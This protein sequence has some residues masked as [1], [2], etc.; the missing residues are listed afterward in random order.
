MGMQWEFTLLDTITLKVVFI[1]KYSVLKTRFNKQ[2]RFAVFLRILHLV[3]Y[4]TPI[5]Y[6]NL[7][8]IPSKLQKFCCN[9]GLRHY[10][11]TNFTCS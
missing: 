5:Y 4:S 2:K 6:I 11:F 10:L 9:K 3:R 8:S 7:L 1:L